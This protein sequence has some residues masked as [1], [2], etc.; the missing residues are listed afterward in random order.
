MHMKLYKHGEY[1]NFYI[2]RLAASNGSGRLDKCQVASNQPSALQSIKNSYHSSIEYGRRSSG[3]RGL[4]FALGITGFLMFMSPVIAIGWEYGYAYEFPKYLAFSLLS[5]I[6]VSSLILGLRLELYQSADE[7]IVFDRKNKRLYRKFNETP[8]NFFRFF[9]TR[10]PV[11]VSEYRWDL[12]DAYHQVKVMSGTGLPTNNH[13]LVFAVKKSKEDSTVID[14]FD[15]GPSLILNAELTLCLWEHIRRFMEDNG[16]HL[17]PYEDRFGV[18]LSPTSWW[19][20]LGK[21]T[22]MG[23]GYAKRWAKTPGMM[24]VLHI[25][26]PIFIPLTLLSATGHW[27]SLKTEAEVPWPEAI[28]KRV[29]SPL[30]IA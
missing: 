12:V 20:C 6:S 18:E 4:I 5:L 9:F 11:V 29:G 13:R 22:F 16:P 14:T 24:A 21:T 23:A 7:P 28:R 30:A 3:P 26:F 25:F 27:L 10:W 19:Q 2:D 17:P 1:I 15:V 8:R